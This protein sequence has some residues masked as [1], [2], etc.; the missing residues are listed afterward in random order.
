LYSRDELYQRLLTVAAAAPLSVFSLDDESNLRRHFSN[1]Y[2]LISHCIPEIP[3]LMRMC[4]VREE[5]VCG[6]VT[7]DYEKFSE[8]CRISPML[9]GN[10]A[11]I[12]A[13]ELLIKIFD[14][15]LAPSEKSCMAVWQACCGDGLGIG[16]EEI[17][18]RMN[19]K[20][21]F[22]RRD[23]FEE[24]ANGELYFGGAKVLSVLSLD[25]LADIEN[26][27]MLSKIRTATDIE[28]FARERCD[29]LLSSGGGYVSL[30]LPR[31]FEFVKPSVYGAEQALVAVRDGGE[32][33]KSQKNMLSVQLLRC[34]VK[35][36]RARGLCLL[37]DAKADGELLALLEYL[38]GS[39]GLSDVL[40]CVDG[41]VAELKRLICELSPD[42]LCR[43]IPTGFKGYSA[44]DDLRGYASA[45]PIEK[46]PHLGLLAR[47]TD[48][49]KSLAAQCVLRRELC[50]ILS[51]GLNGDSDTADR[52]RVTAQRVCY[53]NFYNIT[54]G[55]VVR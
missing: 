29:S 46:L 44:T 15:D 22:V 16:G 5:Y 31:D 21:I 42:I 4:G 53:D 39:V 25:R 50:K 38:H 8:L 18:K 7:S 20:R 28:S 49:Y 19:V 10:C 26:A 3:A 24:I 55:D 52:A 6:D 33:S 2:E 51:E 27:Q 47:V 34:F 14:C 37:M 17:I 30:S 36:M 48:P 12:A 9:V 1:V 54:E 43:V 32:I 11:Y 23:P 40:L 35:A 41:A 13:C 45:F